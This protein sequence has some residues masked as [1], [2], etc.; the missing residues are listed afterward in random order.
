MDD[1]LLAVVQR[2]NERRLVRFEEALDSPQPAA[3]P[4]GTDSDPRRGALASE[5]TSIANHREAIRAEIVEFATHVSQPQSEAVERLIPPAKELYVRGTRHDR[6][7]AGA[8]HRYRIALGLTEGHA[9]ALA[10]I[11][12]MLGRLE[13]PKRAARRAA[14]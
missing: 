3:R 9:E 11:E 5:L 7:R 12:Q 10:I 1:L 2:V 8:H 14:K 4:V 13:K 6:G